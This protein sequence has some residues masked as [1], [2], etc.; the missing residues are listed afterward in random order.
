MY[1]NDLQKKNGKKSKG[2]AADFIQESSWKETQINI[3]LLIYYS[4]VS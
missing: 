2:V 3:I 4:D 1:N